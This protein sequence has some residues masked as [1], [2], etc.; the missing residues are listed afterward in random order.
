[1]EVNFK[2]LRVPADYPTYP[3]YHTGDY[4]E[5]YFYKFYKENKEEFDK[6]GY[7]YIPVFWTNV[8]LT[9]KNKELLQ[10]YLD[11]LPKDKKYFTVSQHDDAVQERLPQGTL[12]FEAGGNRSG[13]PIPLICS[14]LDKKLIKDT[15]KDIFCSFVGSISNNAS[16]RVK[17]YQTY[18]NDKDFYFNTPR[19]W[20]AHVP[21]NNFEE[22]IDTTLRSEFSLCP[23]G[24]GKQSF[25]FYEVMQ[26]NSIP[27]FVYNGDWFPFDKY[28]D[29]NSFSVVIHEND[30][31]TLK[32][33]LK[34]Y[35]EEDKKKMLE[36]GKEVYK[37]YFTMEGMSKNILRYLQDEK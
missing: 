22:F 34:S 8:Y 1:M 33:K 10:P 30:I 19:Q 31:G 13:I 5:E 7:T 2:N 23:R 28:V 26:L 27:V 6:T 36:K 11:Y 25:R 18:M 4:L 16:S 17:L 3:P 35:S 29:W 24:Y 12:S 15:K 32:D 21:K 20:T 37:E 9:S 14:P